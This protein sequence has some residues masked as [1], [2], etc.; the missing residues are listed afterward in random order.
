MDTPTPINP[1]PSDNS[2][3]ISEIFARF[4]G[5]TDFS[6]FC[7]RAC[8]DAEEGTPAMKVL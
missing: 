1:A 2:G 5:V 8:Y 3:H 4:R 7:E 6:P